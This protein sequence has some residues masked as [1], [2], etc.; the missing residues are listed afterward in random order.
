A[1]EEARQADERAAAG[2]PLPPLHGLPVAV[3]D[4]HETAGIRTTSGSPLADHVP[5]RDELVVERMRAAGAVVVGKSNVPEFA[6]GSHTFNPIFGT[7]LNPYDPSRS[8]GGS[9]GGAAAAL[10]TGMVALADGSDQ[11][12]SCRNPAAYNNVVGLRPSPG[13][14]PVK[15]KKL[16]YS[17]LSVQGPLARNVEDLTLMLSVMAGR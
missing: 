12:G 9:S 13:L 6:A 3:K 17:S 14:I 7:T 8:A 10:A 16:L 2:G 15:N 4:T 11:G 1:R 5:E